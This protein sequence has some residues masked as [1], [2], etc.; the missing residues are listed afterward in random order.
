MLA[1]VRKHL[2]ASEATETEQLLPVMARYDHGST[3]AALY[4][5]QNCAAPDDED[6]VSGLLVKLAE[7]EFIEIAPPATLMPGGPC[8]RIPITLLARHWSGRPLTG[9]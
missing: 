6:R 5:A 4:A 2:T 7:L 8:W 1:Y 9:P 3:L